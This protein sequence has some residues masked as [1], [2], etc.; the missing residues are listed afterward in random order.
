VP[1]GSWIRRRTDGAIDVSSNNRSRAP[2]I[3]LELTPERSQ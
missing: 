2:S 3:T 1:I